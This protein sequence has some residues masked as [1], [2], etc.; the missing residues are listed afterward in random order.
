MLGP[1]FRVRILLQISE[2]EEQRS[3][4][5][6]KAQSMDVFAAKGCKAPVVK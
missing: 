6:W 5:D 1:H 4:N 2:T 3:R